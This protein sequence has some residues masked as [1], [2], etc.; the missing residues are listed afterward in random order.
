MSFAL[1]YNTWQFLF[2]FIIYIYMY[3]FKKLIVENALYFI[4]LFKNQKI[5]SKQP[6]LIL[7]FNDLLFPI[8]LAKIFVINNHS[9][10]H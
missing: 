4:L 9:I 7:L 2:S 10:E 3:Y 1:N 8:F 5:S 6:S